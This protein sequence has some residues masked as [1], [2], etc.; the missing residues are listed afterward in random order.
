MVSYRGLEC[1]HTSLLTLPLSRLNDSLSDT[2]SVLA[3]SGHKWDK[4]ESKFKVREGK[5]DFDYWGWREHLSSTHRNT[6]KLMK[7]MRKRQ[8]GGWLTV[9]KY[10]HGLRLRVFSNQIEEFFKTIILVPSKS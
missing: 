10:L 2:R 5:E 4:A 9:R 6:N 1:G 7:S 8:R 3:L